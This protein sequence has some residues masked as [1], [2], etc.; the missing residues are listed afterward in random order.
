MS[1]NRIAI[2]LFLDVHGRMEVKVHL[3][4]TGDEVCLV[5]AFGTRPTHVQLLQCDHVRGVAG[6]DPRNTLRGQL[7]VHADTTVYIIGHDPQ[8]IPASG[9]PLQHVL[10]V[11]GATEKAQCGMTQIIRTKSGLR[12]MYVARQ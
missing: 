4:V 5:H 12:H 10:T 6:D 8:A 1:Q 2:A 3:Q 11:F 7:A 9:T